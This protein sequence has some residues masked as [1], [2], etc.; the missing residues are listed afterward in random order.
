[1]DIFFP[2]IHNPKIIDEDPD[3]IYIELDPPI[4]QE[5]ISEKEIKRVIVIEI[6]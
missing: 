1:M 2:F 5:E 6:L 4:I 3:P